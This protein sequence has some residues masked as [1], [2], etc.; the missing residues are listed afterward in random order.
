MP[1]IPQAC[2]A[3]VKVRGTNA[4]LPKTYTGF[5]RTYT[6]LSIGDGCGIVAGGKGQ[7]P[8]VQLILQQGIEHLD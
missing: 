7:L 8:Y 2:Q 6:G 3:P 4:G 1:V 5:P